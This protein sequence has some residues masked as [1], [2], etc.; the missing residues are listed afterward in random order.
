MRVIDAAGLD[1]AILVGWSY[2]G[3]V[4]LDTL[5]HHLGDPRIAGL[6]FVDANT[7]AAPGHTSVPS[8]AVLARCLDPDMAVSI[9]ARAEFVALCFERRPSDADLAEILAYNHMTSPEILSGLIG[10]PLERDV[11]MARI[12]LPTLVIHGAKDRL[13]LPACAEHTAATIPGAR[14]EMLDHVGHSPHLEDP[15]RVNALLA[16]FARAHL[17]EVTAR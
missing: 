17:P 7:K 4:I 9:A 11:L 15:A 5:E 3:R 13:C 2:G 6:V 10:R 14:L 8:G 12:D 16:A 1:H